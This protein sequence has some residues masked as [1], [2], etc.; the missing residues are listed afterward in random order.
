[1]TEQRIY[2]A[3]SYA[4]GEEGP[5]TLEQAR[6]QV[7]VWNEKGYTSYVGKDGDPEWEDVAVAEALQ[8][9]ATLALSFT[10]REAGI[11]Y[12]KELLQA[13]S[14]EID[15]EGGRFIVYDELEE[16]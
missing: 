2:R 4:G 6:D 15:H 8:P 11:Q 16:L 12:A 3:Y 7:A 10:D 9:A 1:M 14:C 13:L 5:M